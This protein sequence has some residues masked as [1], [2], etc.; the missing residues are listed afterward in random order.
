MPKKKKQVSAVMQRSTMVCVQIVKNTANNMTTPDI[1]VQVE[2]IQDGTAHRIM[3][4]VIWGDKEFFK[5]KY[6]PQTPL[7]DNKQNYERRQ[8]F[9]RRTI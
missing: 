3:Q 9:K 4:N 5:E 7:L 2:N 8:D 6:V 1:K